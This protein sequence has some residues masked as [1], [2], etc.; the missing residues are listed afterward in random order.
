MTRE[1]AAIRAEYV[2]AVIASD[3]E[4]IQTFTAEKTWIASCALLLAM[5]IVAGSDEYGFRACALRRIPE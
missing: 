1:N 2:D 5:T 4:A 3:S